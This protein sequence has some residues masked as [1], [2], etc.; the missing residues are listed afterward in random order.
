MST[1]SRTLSGENPT[2]GF[3][4]SDKLGFL[5]SWACMTPGTRR[6]ATLA[7]STTAS[8]HDARCRTA[9]VG[10]F[11]G[12]RQL[13]C[14]PRLGVGQAEDTPSEDLLGDAHDSQDST[15][16]GHAP[17]GERAG[18]RSAGRAGL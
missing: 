7:R 6:A 10:S 13:D 18:C 3:A 12:A 16:G 1:T 15:G 5:S 11:R 2:G 14:T 4:L 17:G 9:I 8:G